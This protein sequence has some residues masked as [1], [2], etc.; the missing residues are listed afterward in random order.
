[1][2]DVAE[3]E[4]RQCLEPPISHQFL[5]RIRIVRQTTRWHKIASCRPR[6]TIS[7]GDCPHAHDAASR[8]TSRRTSARQSL[9]MRSPRWQDCR[10]AISP[11][12]LSRPKVMSPH[13]YVLHC[14]VKRAK[15]LLADNK[16]S[17]SQIAF[18]AGFSDQSHYT[19]W[20]YPRRLQ[21]DDAINVTARWFGKI[22]NFVVTLGL[23][24]EGSAPPMSRGRNEQDAETRLHR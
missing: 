10:F 12:S 4:S 17:Q 5:L 3:K 9:T 13:R 15:E 1:V 16:M 7:E 19:R 24:L 23:A 21:V 8:T 2:L 20:P 14:R 22:S 11:E 6:S 18:A